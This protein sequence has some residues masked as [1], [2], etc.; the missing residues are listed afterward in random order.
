MCL[1]SEQKIISQEESTA[2]YLQRDEILD[3]LGKARQNCKTTGELL[4]DVEQGHQSLYLQNCEQTGGN[5]DQ[6]V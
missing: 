2:M 6:Q 5:L 3:S 1:E 4:R